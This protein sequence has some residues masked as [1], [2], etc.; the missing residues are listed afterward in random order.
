MVNRLYIEGKLHL[1]F[2]TIY[3]YILIFPS[4]FTRE[5]WSR[6]EIKVGVR[7]W[8]LQNLSHVYEF[9]YQITL[10][11]FLSLNIIYIYIYIVFPRKQSDV[12]MYIHIGSVLTTA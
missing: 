7:D 11:G 6:M 1:F 10:L 12:V 5:C 4:I 3:I 2:L 8:M 9:V